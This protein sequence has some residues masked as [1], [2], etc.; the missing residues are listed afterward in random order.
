MSTPSTPGADPIQIRF[1]RDLRSAG[2]ETGVDAGQWRVIA[3]TWPTLTVAISLGND[4]EVGMQLD[5]EDYPVEAPAGRAW[6]LEADTPLP[7]AQ[8]PMTGGALEV[9]RTEGW[10]DA[11]LGAPY[12]GCD[13]RALKGHP[14]WP[15]EHP[16]RC[17][18]PTR[19]IVFYLQELHRELAG[20]R[21]RTGG[22]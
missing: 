9:F 7:S 17:W 18:N 4:I 11:H 12:L 6:D 10:N 5:V 3:F 19:T 16:D 13:R 21:P 20:T 8:W 22:A 15:I 2:V 1:E 14:N